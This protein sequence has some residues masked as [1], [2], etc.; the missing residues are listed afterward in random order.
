[1]CVWFNF[2]V[3]NF[4]F[5]EEGEAEGSKTSV[6]ASFLPFLRRGKLRTKNWFN[7]SCSSVVQVSSCRLF[8]THNIG[9]CQDSKLN[10]FGTFFVRCRPIFDVSSHGD[11]EKS[12]KFFF[13]H[14]EV[15]Q[16]IGLTMDFEVLPIDLFEIFGR[17]FS[18]IIMFACQIWEESVNGK[19]E[20][21]AF[22]D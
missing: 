20:L 16:S 8:F 4:V 11:S 12:A 2:H 21:Q 9:E 10:D 19:F 3:V 15:L 6:L 17:W 1:M 18:S 22:W 13:G 5:G 7:R 14:L